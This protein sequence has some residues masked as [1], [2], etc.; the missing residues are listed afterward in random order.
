MILVANPIPS[1]HWLNEPEYAWF[2]NG[3]N[4]ACTQ[5]LAIPAL[6]N[7]QDVGSLYFAVMTI[8]RENGIGTDEDGKLKI[9]S[10]LRE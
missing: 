10:T 6:A 4:Y 1:N 8:L 3:Y 2:K 9:L 5:T 7:I